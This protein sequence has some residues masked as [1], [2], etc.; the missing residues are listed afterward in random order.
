MRFD[1][2][3]DLASPQKNLQKMQRSRAAWVDILER[4]LAF[5]DA[6]P[7]DPIPASLAP[8]FDESHSATL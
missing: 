2:P 3:A 8:L 1:A 4:F 6:F 7:L 5:G